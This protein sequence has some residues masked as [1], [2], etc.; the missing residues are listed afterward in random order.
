MIGWS[1]TASC[2][3]Q[4]GQP[5]RLAQRR[6]PLA[7][8]DP[9]DRL[10]VADYGRA[11]GRDGRADHLEPDQDVAQPTFAER[12]DR[13]A[14]DEV[15][16]IALDQPAHRCAA[17]IG[18][19]IGVLT[20]DRVLLLEPQDAL[21]FDTE[22][23]DP[24]LRT[25]RQD[26]IPE[27]GRLVGRHVQFVGQLPDEPDP[28]DRGRDSGHER[29]ASIEI[30]Q[31]LGRHVDVGQPL[32][33]V[34]GARSG[35]VHRRVP[36]GHVGHIDPPIRGGQP[37]AQ[38]A[39]DGVEAARSG[40]DQVAVVAEP[41]D[42]P[43][44]EDD[45]GVIGHRAVADPPDAQVAEPVRVE[46]VEELAG[47]ASAHVEFAQG[48]DV[49]QPDAL[50]DSAT[51]GFHIAVVERT[52]PVAHVHPVRAEGLVAVVQRG[53][54]DGAVVRP[55][56]DRQRDRL[57]RRPVGRQSGRLTRNAAQRGRHEGGVAVALLAL[58]GAH[59]HGAV[60]LERLEQF[61]A[62][63]NALGEFL[64]GHVLA[65]ADERLAPAG[66]GGRGRVGACREGRLDGVGMA[67][68]GR[69]RRIGGRPVA[70]RGHSAGQDGTGRD[71]VVVD[72]PGD[73]AGDDHV[74][75]PCNRDPLGQARLEGQLEPS[76]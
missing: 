30:A 64:G 19:G 71:Q 72:Q 40:G 74:G 70:R 35:Q 60:A 52:L 69:D 47:I 68:Q 26:P 75:R 2:G 14:P 4:P 8:R 13:V 43:V 65:E 57:D 3:R 28:Q 37:P 44:I 50:V 7:A 42:R 31:A 51:F 61:K 38:P 45:P 36:G 56:E 20:D 24:E 15:R 16:A 32:Q 10:A 55:G 59:G 9:S 17:R 12:R 5:D 49:D 34:P 11:L 27:V 67:G 48:R 22:R 53:P 29:L 33:H 23:A 39:V 58:A 73:P 6:A 63:T 21:G 76:L 18:Q 66:E 41:R 1:S 46:P 25:G 62:F 54:A